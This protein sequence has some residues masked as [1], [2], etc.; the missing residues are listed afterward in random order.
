MVKKQKT[1]A[2]KENGAQQAASTAPPSTYQIWQAGLAAL[3]K[4]QEE[5]GRVFN[6]L[7]QERGELQQRTGSTAEER[8]AGPGDTIAEVAEGASL[9]A[10]VAFDQ[11]EH[12]FEE[13]VARALGRL[14]VPGAQ[15]IET[16]VR[17]IGQLQMRVAELSGQ[18]ASAAKPMPNGAGQPVVQPVAARAVRKPAVKAALAAVKAVTKPAAKAAPKRPV[19]VKVTIK[20]SGAASATKV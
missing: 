9:Q 19:A 6:R 11:L 3:V 17:Q 10:A 1:L 7:V 5:G 12:L 16:L 8:G 20:K 2:Q 18:L 14:G 15:D 4:A 13:R